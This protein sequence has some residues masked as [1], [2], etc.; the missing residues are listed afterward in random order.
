MSRAILRLFRDEGKRT[1]RQKGRLMWLIEDHGP[2]VEVGGHM[3]MAE[4]F[5]EKLVAEIESCANGGHFSLDRWRGGV[6]WNRI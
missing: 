3:R 4:A 1:D 2:S 6:V 5:R